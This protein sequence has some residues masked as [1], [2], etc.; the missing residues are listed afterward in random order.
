M[1]CRIAEEETMTKTD[2]VNKPRHYQGTFGLEAIDVMRNFIFSLTGMSA[3]YWKDVMKYLLRFQKKNG[4]EDLKKAKK[5][6]EWLIDEIE[7]R[8]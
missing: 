6:L 1:D 4:L 3:C 7:N 8:G 5:N 2:N